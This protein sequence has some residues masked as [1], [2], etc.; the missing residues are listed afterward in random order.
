MTRD[1]KHHLLSSSQSDF[2]SHGIMLGLGEQEQKQ[3]ECNCEVE[4]PIIITTKLVLEGILVPVVGVFG[5]VGN[6]LAVV[7]LR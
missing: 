6:G 5:L 1:N 7:V 2:L 4:D 3:G